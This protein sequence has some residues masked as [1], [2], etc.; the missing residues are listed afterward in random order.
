M[1]VHLKQRFRSW[2]VD[3]EINRHEEVSKKLSFPRNGIS[4]TDTEAKTVYPDIIIH[5]RGKGP[6]VLVIEMKKKG[7]S[8][9][10]DLKKLHAYKDQVGYKYACFI[11]INIGNYH[12]E[13]PTWL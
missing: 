10:F 6:N 8:S 2:H 3:C 13:E 5:K 1:A 4:W 12:L 9:E 7:R 11:W